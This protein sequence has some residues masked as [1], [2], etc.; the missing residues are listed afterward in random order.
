MKIHSVS[1]WKERMP[2]KR[3]YTIAT[4]RVDAVENLFVRIQGQNGA[5]GLGAASPAED[6]TGESVADCEHA[7]K[8]HLAPLLSGAD[9]N[10]FRSLLR[11]LKTAMVGAPGAR[12]A[13]DIALHDLLAKC[14]GLPLVEVLGRVH[15]ALPTS[16]TI[17]IGPVDETLEQAGE[18][19]A[20]GFAV[21]KVKTG[22][23]VDED[24]ERLVRL[25]EHFGAKIVIRVDANQGYGLADYR[26]FL[27]DTST[28]QVEFVEQPLPAADLESMRRLPE[29]VRRKTAADESLLDPSSALACLGSPQPFG[30]FNIKLMKCGGIAPGLRIAEL[31][32]D[33]GIDLM[34]G[35]MDE[36]AISIAAALHVALACPAT[37]YLDLDGSLDLAHDIATGGF[38]LKNGTMYPVDAPGLGAMLI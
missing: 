37:R 12:A 21:L 38:I 23:Q 29:A 17:G 24:I 9:L 31:A 11:R 35:C 25:R 27:A 7:L 13:V 1:Y 33:A 19:V 5:V 18:W 3:P 20:Q 30:I 34:W 26:R 10:H 14:L 16:I 8:S 6:V 2:L 28:L 32:E 4:Q 15:D 36:S 22:L